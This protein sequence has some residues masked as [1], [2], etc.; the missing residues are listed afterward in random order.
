MGWP[1][2]VSLKEQDIRLLC[3][4][5]LTSAEYFSD[6]ISPSAPSDTSTRVESDK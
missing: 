4:Y 6:V 2:L 1:V 5:T 3:S